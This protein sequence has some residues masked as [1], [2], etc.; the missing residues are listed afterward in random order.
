ML[1]YLLIPKN[2]YQT[3]QYVTRQKYSP[4]STDDEKNTIPIHYLPTHIITNINYFCITDYIRVPLL[5]H[6]HSQQAT[7]DKHIHTEKRKNQ[8]RLIIPTVIHS[9]LNIVYPI[10]TLP[11]PPSRTTVHIIIGK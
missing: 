9:V 6:A 2:R 4:I 8:T 5:I 10:N 11:N 7:T 3:S 1:T